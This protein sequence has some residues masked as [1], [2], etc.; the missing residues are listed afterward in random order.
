MKGGLFMLYSIDNIDNYIINYAYE[1]NRSVTN[2][3]LQKI[4]YFVY[5]FY[6]AFTNEE[7]FDEGFEAWAY[8]PV[9]RKSYVRYSMFGAEIIPPHNNYFDLL[10]DNNF[11]YDSEKNASRFENIF[12][13][14]T[15]KIINNLLDLLLPRPVMDLVE[16][17]HSPNGPWSRSY[18]EGKKRLISKDYIFDYFKSFRDTATA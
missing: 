14:S 7:L 6:Y 16:L 2:L 13:D 15:R 3:K 18:E 4:L 12:D 1:K 8:G 11:K 10:F 9:V 5:G 17:S